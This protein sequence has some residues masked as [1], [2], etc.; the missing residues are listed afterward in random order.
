MKVSDLKQELKRRN[1]PVSGSKPQ[2]I[3]RLKPF[4]GNSEL[5]THSGH[6]IMDTP[7]PLS[8]CSEESQAD[9][10]DDNNGSPHSIEDEHYSE[11]M[12]ISEPKTPLTPSKED[13]VKEQ[14]RQIE[15]LQRKLTLS[16]L[17]LQQVRAQPVLADQKAQR[18]LQQRLQAR[19][20]M[21]LQAQQLQAL[22]Q[23]QSE[24]IQK[25]QEERQQQHV[26]FQNTKNLTNGLILNGNALVLNQLVQGKV[27]LI[28]NRTNSLP[29]FL[30]VVP[31][32]QTE[33]IPTQ[34]VQEDIKP[35]PLYDEATKQ[36]KKEKNNVKSQIVDDVLEILIK[37]GE[38]PP[39]AAN[40]PATPNLTPTNFKQEPVFPNSEPNDNYLNLDNSVLR[41]LGL[42]LE[43]LDAIDF[44]QLDM[45]INMPQNLPNQADYDTMSVPMETD[46]SDWLDSL[47]P[48]E[49]PQSNISVA[50]IAQFESDLSSYD[51]IMGN[52]QDPF[53]LFSLED[54]KPNNELT[55]SL[56]W[57][58]IDFAA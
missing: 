24:E 58:K 6:I 18:L 25:Q 36:I 46:D 42:D 30:N 19:Q 13:I 16:Q 10:Q 17:Q 48:T 2:L 12:D 8:V 41:D 35:P 39:S 26:A 55:N 40:D 50:P 47:L 49:Q 33:I 9:T 28:N 32:I 5:V 51:P 7:A 52:T 37:N 45:D 3:E 44:T 14:Q 57:D 31:V 22:Q 21:A 27:K 38:L 4:L 56:S 23:I 20:Q 43:S 54:F 53:D 34:T 15:E 29:N 1:L 11:S